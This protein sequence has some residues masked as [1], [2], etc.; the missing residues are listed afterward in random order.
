[1]KRR[2]PSMAKPKDHHHA[3]TTSN[4]SNNTNGA[5]AKITGFVSRARESVQVTMNTIQQGNNATGFFQD[6]S[7]GNS[8]NNGSV[9]NKVFSSTQSSVSNT[10]VDPEEHSDRFNY[11]LLI[12]LYTLQGI[13]MGLSASIPFLLQE[14]I[15]KMAAAAA[16]LG[17]AAS[18]AAT[19]SA[20][21]V[22]AAEA[23]RASYNAN[24]IFALCSWP[25][26]LKLLWAPIVDAIYF[27]RFGRRK[28]CW[29]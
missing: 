5:R 17:T 16:S 2:P 13:P 21:A 25:F 24:A 11:A 27:K 18:V 22:A 15:Q 8:N 23:A 1:M 28:S 20:H 10:S 4:D 9:N 26:S 3:G 12:V 14:K 7:N 19:G 29:D 6:D